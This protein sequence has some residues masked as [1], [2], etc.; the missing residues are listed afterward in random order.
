MSWAVSQIGSAGLRAARLML[1]GKQESALREVARE[2]IRSAVENAVAAEDRDVVR[3]GLL[4]E[5]PDSGEINPEGALE[6]REAVLS[7]IIPPLTALA[8]QGYRVD[9]GHLADEIV[10]QI[11]SG[12]RANAAHGGP[13]QSLAN[14]LRDKRLVS[15]AEA[16]AA[17]SEATVEQL[18]AIGRSLEAQAVPHGD[19]PAGDSPLGRATVPPRGASNLPARNPHFTGRTEV[20]AHLESLLGQGVVAVTA[21]QGLGGIGKTE[22]ALE[23]AW[24]HRERYAV[25]WW[26]HASN[27]VEMTADLVRL[28]RALGLG[29]DANPEHTID[30]LRAEMDTRS[31]WLLVFDNASDATAVRSF[32]PGGGGRVLVTSRL[33]NWTGVATV[34]PVEV[35][36]LPEA[37]AY[38]RIGT[39]C[40]SPEAAELAGELGC[41]PLALAQAAGYITV[42][43]CSVV[44]YLELYRSAT[45]RI[46]AEGPRPHGYP[47]TV[48]TTWLLHFESLSDPAIDLL[49]LASF[50]A[51]DA[52]P[53]GVLLYDTAATQ[54]LP[55][56]L[57]AAVSDPIAC[58][59]I[60]GELVSTS[61]LTRLDDHTIR[62]HRLVQEVTRSRLSKRQGAAWTQHVAELV[63]AALPAQPHIHENWDTMSLLAPHA[64]VVAIRV[65]PHQ[66]AAP[67]ALRLLVGLAAYLTEQEHFEAAKGALERALTLALFADPSR[68][69][70]ADV[71]YSLGLVY[72]GMG[73]YKTSIEMIKQTLEIVERIAGRESPEAITPL[74]QIGISYNGDRNYAE[75]YR[76][77]DRVAD[78]FFSARFELPAEVAFDV[79]MTLGEGMRGAGEYEAALRNIEQ[80]LALAKSLY[81]ES[82]QAVA[83]ARVYLSWVYY[84]QDDHT[85]ADAQMS[86]AI[87]IIRRLHGA[88]HPFTQRLVNRRAQWR[89]ER[90]SGS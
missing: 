25:T 74:L 27:Q 50:L 18:Q 89:A 51:P 28:A 81:G 76:Y 35:M 24:I 52:I 53:V 59:A 6:L 62:I 61:L 9:P 11:A 21:V 31:D 78:V 5:G 10:V 41:L 12:I 17:A 13:L 19:I 44:R 22:L 72:R 58:E 63:L 70:E 30:L 64:Q 43:N 84:S 85:A 37:I 32:L 15:A 77:F 71:R 42:R 68:R 48:A 66:R 33:R 8:E 83:Y 47:Y 36:T 34:C 20:L 60:L 55:E 57:R 75:A 65:D 23:Y 29:T 40:D 2:A 73:D 4:V 26:V 67:S 69:A 86:L 82:S 1:P 46:L 80:G 38:L 56:T 16:T 45:Q 54:S 90:Q 88:N 3:D 14:A 49:I 87:E 79:L 39:G 7:K